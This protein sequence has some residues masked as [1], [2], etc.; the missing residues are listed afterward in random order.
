MGLPPQPHAHCEGPRQP[1]LDAGLSCL[2]LT[3]RSVTCGWWAGH[4]GFLS[5]WQCRAGVEVPA[6]PPPHPASFTAAPWR[7]DQGVRGTAGQQRKS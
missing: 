3:C 1:W 6:P 2:G 5:P 7:S 4:V